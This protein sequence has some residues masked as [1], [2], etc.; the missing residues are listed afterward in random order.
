MEGTA[1]PGARSRR[2][3]PV[4]TRVPLAVLVWC[5][6]ASAC[7]GGGATSA[8]SGNGGGTPKSGGSI[9]VG[10]FNFT[11]LDP[12]QAAYIAGS[13]PYM[14]LVYGS[15]FLPPGPGGGE[16]TPDLATGYVFSDHNT[17]LT[18]NLRH[19][20]TFQDGTPFD[21]QAVVW[22]LQRYSSPQ[23]TNSQYLNTASSI[24]A[25]R[26]DQVVVKFSQPNVPIIAALGNTSAGFM[27]SPTA[28]SRMGAAKY[29]ISPVGAGPFRISSSVANQTTVLSKSASYWDAAHVYLNQITLKNT[30]TDQNVQ[31]TDL[32]SGA[33]QETQFPGILTPPN[34][35]TQAK[36]NHQLSARTSPDL[37]Y[38]LL[39]VNTYTA[40][41]N[42]PKARE[43]IA[44]CTD[45]ESITRN[46]QQGYAKPAYIL[47]GTD[48]EH[49]PAGGVNGAKKLMPYSYDVS[50][51]K[52]IVQ[53]L[54][55]LS[56]QIQAYTA[57]N[58]TVATAL[59]QQWADC[60][61][62]AKV[63][64]VQPPAFLVNLGTGAYQ[65]GLTSTGGASSPELW[66]SYQTP[67]TPIGKY[68]FNDAQILS[69]IHQTYAT[70]DRS[71]LQQ[72]WKQI[73]QRENELA[74]DFPLMSSGNYVFY[75]KCLSGVEFYSFGVDF[76]HVYL[77]CAV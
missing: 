77:T 64:N 39:P 57:H 75:N 76:S 56:F 66:T 6:I 32:A 68:G 3:A 63:Q 44:R 22:N 74:V 62:K 52:A 60:G 41:F 30:G 59:T 2:L 17:T 29:G 26:A 21:A 35:I 31:Y 36:A 10:G 8:G 42:N 16:V 13:N 48:G 69:L 33:I 19:N 58:L 54:G 55:G 46:L 67:T 34:V 28:F 45:R 70:T 12:G 20:V 61:I 51:G 14:V 72:L 15:L 47:S 37:Q 25:S 65:M 1:L 4:R 50:R 24:T 7:G 11:Q 43:A 9:S 40:P 71:S 73:W 27:G 23:S 38:A 18:I 49:V 5:L 53:S